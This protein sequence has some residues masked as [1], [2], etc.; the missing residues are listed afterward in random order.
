M[1]QL[2][3]ALQYL[4]NS[5]FD[6]GKGLAHRDIKPGNIFLMI[7]QSEEGGPLELIIKMG[8]LGNAKVQNTDLSIDGN[9]VGGTPAYQAP[10]MRTKGAVSEGFN[11]F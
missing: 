7:C 5:E 3:L 6:Q 1:I 10:E 8:D 11:K 4:H 9:T 2:A